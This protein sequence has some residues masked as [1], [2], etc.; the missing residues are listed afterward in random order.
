ME[1]EH[2][3][4]TQSAQNLQK[5]QGASQ[6]CPRALWAQLSPQ[7]KHYETCC[8]GE[9]E[10]ITRAKKPPQPFGP[11]LWQATAISVGQTIHTKETA[12]S[13]LLCLHTILN[14]SVSG[15]PGVQQRGLRKSSN[16]LGKQI[17]LNFTL[18]HPALS[19][20]KRKSHSM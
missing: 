12:V 4:D 5:E 3:C 9:T 18:G 11:Q 2:S 20:D 17:S 19:R 8:A 15:L 7:I 14:C 1:S 13:L 16:R 10:K 6:L